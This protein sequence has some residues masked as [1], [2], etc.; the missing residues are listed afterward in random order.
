MM[1]NYYIGEIAVA[2][3]SA[4]IAW[5]AGRR[6]QK[7][8]ARRI[9]VEVLEKAIQTIDRDVVSPLAQRLRETQQELE[10]LEKSCK[11]LQDAINKIYDCD[12]LPSCPVVAELRRQEGGHAK[13]AEP[14]NGGS[15]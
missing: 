7:S 3:I 4:M 6:Q 9:E 11:Q 2:A 14:G 10:K 15:R 8:E 12:S 13:P 5:V 1:D